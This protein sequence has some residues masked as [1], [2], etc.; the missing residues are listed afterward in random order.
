MMNDANGIRP[1]AR[2]E[3][4][5]AGIGAN[6]PKNMSSNSSDV[7]ALFEQFLERATV[8]ERTKIEKHLEVCDADPDP[9]RSAL[10]R[11]LVGHIGA[12][13]SRVAVQSA[14]SNT[15]Q[16]FIPDGKYRKQVFA[17]EDTGDGVMRLYLPDVLE[18]ALRAGII[19][20]AEEPNL[21]TVPGSAWR[22]HVEL[23]DAANTTSPGNHYKHMLGWNRKALRVTL[24]ISDSDT[25]SRAGV[26]MAMAEL[27]A[28]EWAQPAE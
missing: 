11:Q 20:P 6:M 25:D 16:F 8:K 10:W 7:A 24:P 13:A 17:L 28:R 15:W 19:A 21:Y 9:G 14:G 22:V 12:L 18:D 2:R 3:A 23:L 27:A 1:M 5:R 26:A 4:A